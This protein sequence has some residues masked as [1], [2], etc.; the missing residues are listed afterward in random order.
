MADTIGL[1]ANLALALSF[2]V[3]LV[4]GIQQVR[5]AARDR[6]ERLTIETLNTFQ[7]REFTELMYWILNREMPATRDALRALPAND[8][9]MFMQFAQE[10]E[11]LGLVVAERIVSLDLVEKSLGTF[12]TGAWAKYKTLFSDVRTTSPDPYLG[13]YF[14]W[15]AERIEERMRTRP[16]QPFYLTGG[17]R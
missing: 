6:R 5:A 17:S 7:T 4:F 12:V 16:R 10:M 14:Q 13:E 1:L 2:I 15:L 9:I 3:G 11:S 8:Q